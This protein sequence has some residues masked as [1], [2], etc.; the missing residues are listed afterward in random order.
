MGGVG[1]EEEEEDGG[2]NDTAMGVP[3][4]AA[5]V[6]WEGRAGQGVVEAGGAPGPPECRT[7]ARAEGM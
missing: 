2:A 7:S 6:R 4:A 1:E 5:L 3:P